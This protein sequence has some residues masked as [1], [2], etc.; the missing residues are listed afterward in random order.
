VRAGQRVLVVPGEEAIEEIVAEGAVRT[1]K[2]A[3]KPD[4][5]VLGQSGGGTTC[6]GKVVGAI[7]AVEL[8]D[9]VSIIRLEVA[10]D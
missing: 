9:V 6:A 3:V 1:A 7:A 5:P 4:C 8:F 10:D 2:A